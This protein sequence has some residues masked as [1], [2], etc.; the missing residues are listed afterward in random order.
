[1]VDPKLQEPDLDPDQHPSS[2]EPA[3]KEEASTQE[4]EEEETTENAPPFGYHLKS[5]DP[6]ADEDNAS[7]EVQEQAASEDSD[8]ELAD[9]ETS[10]PDE[11][12]EEAPSLDVSEPEEPVT[13]PQGKVPEEIDEEPAHEPDSGAQEEALAEARTQV[14]EEAPTEL[15]ENV[16]PTREVPTTRLKELEERICRLEDALALQRH[17]KKNTGSDNGV[18]EAPDK[19]ALPTVRHPKPPTG[20]QSGE[21]ELKTRRPW[22]VVEIY[23]EL[24]SILRMYV[25]PRH[26]MSWYARI[27]PIVF[28]A[29]MLTSS[30]WLPGIPL[31][32]SFL[33]LILAY[34]LFKI[35]I[36]ESTRYRQSSPDLPSSLRL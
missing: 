8:E 1:M 36:R 33:D 27:L 16:E 25:D 23:N 7:E 35:L 22:L 6:P 19:P 11:P 9:T 28:L 32:K 29:L 4:P 14:R 31:L 24:R 26:R 13:S 34:F 10:E 12:P 17:T 15:R 3:Q 18:E 21:S 20:S 5:E 30:L 2:E